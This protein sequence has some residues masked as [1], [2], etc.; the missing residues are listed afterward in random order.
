MQIEWDPSKAKSN[1]A[2]HGIAFEEAVES[3]FDPFAI[4]GPDERH[5]DRELRERTIGMSGRLRV[6]VVITTERE[7]EVIRIISARKA[8]GYEKSQYQQAVRRHRRGT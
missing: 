3:L 1:E 8:N 6:L 7:G 2:K 4:T 5:S